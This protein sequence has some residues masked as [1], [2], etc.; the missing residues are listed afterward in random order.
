MNDVFPVVSSVS[1]MDAEAGSIV[2]IIRSDGPKL[3]LVADHF[4][5]GV[6][7]FVWLN[8]N[9][10][11]RPSVI[12]AEKWQNDPSVLRYGPNIRFELGTANDELDPSGRNFWETAGVIVSIGDDLFIRAAPQD[13]VYGMHKLVNVRNGSVYPERPPSS[14]WTF[15]SWRL[16]IRDPAVHRDVMLTEFSVTSRRPS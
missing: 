14:L 1:L 6:R 11:N 8:P 16:W 3:A 5:N 9:F 4:A 10:Q 13:Y 2:K 15:L 7:S 12:F